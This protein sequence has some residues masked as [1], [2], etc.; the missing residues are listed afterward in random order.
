MLIFEH[1][2]KLYCDSKERQ[3]LP[4]KIFEAID[5]HDWP[6]NVRELENVLKRYLT[7]Q[8]LDFIN[9][10]GSMAVNE[11]N[12]SSKEFLQDSKGL[13]D[14]VELFEKDYIAKVLDH[15]QWHRGKTA[16]M[17]NIPER[18]LYRKLKQF[19]LNKS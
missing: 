3:S 7:I 18:T 16:K 10:Q 9:P 8:R 14:A 17:L 4:V 6:G 11:V 13:R 15:N 12:G 2:L 1:F 5:N 19:K